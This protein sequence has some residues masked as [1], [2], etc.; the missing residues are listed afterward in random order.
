MKE[1]KKFET[2]SKQLLS[3]MINSIYSNNEIFLRELISN[4]SDA[5]DKYR[6][7]SLTEPDKYPLREHNIFITLDKK[8]R[9]ISISDNGVGMSKEDLINNLGT[10][11]K[12]GSK[13][14][15]KK[16]NES[17]EKGDIDI[18]GQF[19]V[20]FYSAFMVANKIEVLT[21]K[22]NE[23]AYLFTSDGEESYSIEEATKDSGGTLITIYLKKDKDEINYSKYLEEY[24]IRNLVKRYSDYIR[25]PI[26]MEVTKSK[27]KLDKDGKEIEGKTEEYQEIETLNSM[28]P[29][30][31]KNKN[32]VKDEEL[33]NFYKEKFSDYEDPL[34]S[35]FVK[36]DGLVTYDSLLY[37]PSH[38]P[39]DL[40]SEN[41]E[42]GL[43]LYS[44]GIF[45]KEKAPE[46]VPDYLKFVKGLVDSP[47]FNLNISREI[48]QETPMM[49]KVS[50]N[51]EKKIIAKL[52]EVKEGE[53]E[54]YLKFWS[55][56]GE[57]IKFGIY[58]SYGFKKDLLQDLLIFKSLNSEDDKYISLK[59]YV[60]HKTK[61]QKYI[62][63]ASGESVSSI[64]NLP[65]IEKYKSKGIDVLLLDQKIDEFAIMM[66]RE[67]EKLE[68]KSI[69]DE[70]SD[71]VSKEEKEKVEQ[72]STDNK[73]LLDTLK[74]A[75]KG[76]VDDVVISSKLVDSPVCI[77]T[78][79]G[80]SLEMEKT[81]NEQPG[82][83][84]KVT[85]QKVLEINPDHEL[86][87]AF[88]SIQSEDEL[89]S[90]YASILYDEAMILE[91]REISNRVE[92]VKK[93]NSLFSKALKK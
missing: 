51:I 23:E 34:I 49:K 43:Q 35:L 86:F 67:Y 59:E 17:K 25:Y 78:K 11:A 6:Y 48:L 24:E 68:F 63:Y 12:S 83:E 90:E 55:A 39:Y 16:I 81:L 10:I 5:I 18:I 41:Y 88:S 77:S 29:L 52:K 60:E 79:D 73:R 42:K 57:H 91:G 38:A 33:N 69:S 4:A 93:I 20:G 36:V 61:D 45:I 50:E 7:L 1:V 84:E 75:L 87:E 82:N 65:Q 89:V 31:K 85:A 37:I 14:F 44:K 66:L 21:K 30:W 71:D 62:Y 70:T 74:E 72:V 9:T 92:F 40:Y 22:E 46:L 80:L 8:K 32:D 26:Q 13:E 27:P 64:K 19:G 15:L 58:Q 54:K 28:I 2:E 47:D 53:Y 56:F 76:K 3:L